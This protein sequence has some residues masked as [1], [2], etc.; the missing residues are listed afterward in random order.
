MTK[1]SLKG[2]A[3]TTHINKAHNISKNITKKEFMEFS[4]NN[5]SENSDKTL[6]YTNLWWNTPRNKIKKTMKKT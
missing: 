4:T 5:E 2:G 6:K 1:P 3:L